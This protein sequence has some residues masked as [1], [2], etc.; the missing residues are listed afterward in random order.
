[1]SSFGDRWYKEY[2]DH[3]LSKRWP[4]YDTVHHFT[5]TTIC[6]HFFEVSFSSRLVPTPDTNCIR[7]SLYLWYSILFPDKVSMVFL[8]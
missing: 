7:T 4:G 1:M 8:L 3:P 5:S 6:L 2:L